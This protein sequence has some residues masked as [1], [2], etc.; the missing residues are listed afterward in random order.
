M[1]FY[2]A[3]IITDLKKC[4]LQTKKFE[5]FLV[6]IWPNDPRIGCKSPFNLFLQRDINLK[7]E[8]E[9]FEGEFEKDEIVEI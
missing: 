9:E 8:L 7:E 1:N 3:K 6:K 4:H 5:I 2:L